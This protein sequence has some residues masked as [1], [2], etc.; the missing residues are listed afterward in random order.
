M[1]GSGQL[2][3]DGKE[4]PHSTP[5]EINLH[6]L[7][8]ASSFLERHLWWTPP[9]R[10]E[11]VSV[12]TERCSLGEVQSLQE[13]SC[14]QERGKHMLGNMENVSQQDQRKGKRRDGNRMPGSRHFEDH[15]F[16]K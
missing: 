1:K 6:R 5:S 10:P 3:P 4:E 15:I 12:P 8:S 11:L 2:Y 13:L 9:Y 16:N 7:A 14:F